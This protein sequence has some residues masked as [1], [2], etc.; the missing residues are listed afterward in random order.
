MMG[1]DNSDGNLFGFRKHGI[2]QRTGTATPM[3]ESEKKGATYELSDEVLDLEKKDATKQPPKPPPRKKEMDPSKDRVVEFGLENAKVIDREDEGILEF[4]V[5]GAMS[6]PGKSKV[7]R[8][9]TIRDL[10]K[11][12][13]GEPKLDY[14]SIDDEEE[15]RD[16]PKKAVGGHEQKVPAAA[17]GAEEK[18][19]L[20]YIPIDDD[21][22]IPPSKQAPP[23]K[24][25]PA[26]TPPK[27]VPPPPPQKDAP[28]PQR[29]PE[30]AKEEAEEDLP[31]TTP[32]DAPS[33]YDARDLKEMRQKDLIF[34]PHCKSKIEI[35]S[36]KR[37]IVV[38]CTGCGK[39]GTLRY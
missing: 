25:E 9:T 29:P 24:K 14:I 3:P 10:K 20:D 35:P 38:K 1:Q 37:P 2:I 28:R 22:A 16:A 13:E 21:D 23:P 17:A 26:Q 5:E 7:R 30:P 33:N 15:K 32:V 27:K 4:G 12:G 31:M 39:K 6:T 36:P 8:Q 34:C 11:S 19:D 18:E